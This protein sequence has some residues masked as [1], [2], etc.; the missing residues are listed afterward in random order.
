MDDVIIVTMT[1]FGR[2]AQENGSFGTDHGNAA[3]W[4]VLGNSIQGGVYLNGIWPGLSTEDLYQQ[5]YLAKTVDY[6]DIFSDILFNHLGQSETDLATLL[7]GHTY[8]N[9]GLFTP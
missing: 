5:R 1:E 6:R 8:N 2:T 7:P 4:F 9:L 3:S